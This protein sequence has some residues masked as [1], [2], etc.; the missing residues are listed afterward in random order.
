MG[1]IS[2]EMVNGVAVVKINRPKVNAINDEMVRELKA[3]FDDI[4]RDPD[5]CAVV[6]TAEGSFF[7]F[8]LDVPGF[9]EY[10]RD[11]FERSFMQFAKLYYSMFNLPKPLVAAVNGHAAGAGCILALAC[12][13]RLM[14]PGKPKIGLNEI[15][16]GATVPYGVVEMLIHAVGSSRASEI[17]YGGAFYS[18]E[19][20]KALGL[21]NEV[22][23][24]EGLLEAAVKRAADLGARAPE[25]FA[26]I[27]LMLKSASAARIV[28][29]EK[30]SIKE[31]IDIW[32]S[33]K[34]TKM[35]EKIQIR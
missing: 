29:R 25:A 24:L 7:S 23:P 17:L 10:K 22:L 15:T 19:E 20:A 14:A 26:S 16:F 33:E 3:A 30:D 11:Q 18:A 35:R 12:D 1:I 27:K 9:L 34:V 4:A 21:V 13:Q 5:K 2:Q 32:Y 28:S 31:F 8:G 6:L